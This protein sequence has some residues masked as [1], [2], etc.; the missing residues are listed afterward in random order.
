MEVHIQIFSYITQNTHKTTEPTAL[1]IC[2]WT[3]CVKGFVLL[4]EA[5]EVWFFFCCVEFSMSWKLILHIPLVWKLGK[6]ITKLS[7]LTLLYASVS[8]NMSSRNEHCHTQVACCPTHLTS[9]S[10]PEISASTKRQLT[11]V[12][13]FCTDSKLFP[14]LTQRVRLWWGWEG[15]D[16]KSSTTTPPRHTQTS[17]ARH[18]NLTT[19]KPHG[20]R[21]PSVPHS[22]RNPCQRSLF[23]LLKP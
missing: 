10:Y 17:K 20:R 4:L 3:T 1:N 22:L 9:L 14:F 12:S 16:N 5:V 18:K 6:P 13:L 23:W 11:Y 15:G 2:L 19:F 7:T 8:K 21:A